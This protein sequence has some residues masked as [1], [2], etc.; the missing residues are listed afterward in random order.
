MIHMLDNVK[1]R[2][3]KFRDLESF[4]ISS[5][6]SFL[7]E[8]LSLSSQ[9]ACSINIFEKTVHTKEWSVSLVTK[10]GEK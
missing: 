6:S 1:E 9:V 4:I 2:H 8:K 10:H 3:L 5:R 7:R